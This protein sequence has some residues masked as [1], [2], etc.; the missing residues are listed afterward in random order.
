MEGAKGEEVVGVKKGVVGGGGVRLEARI[1][2][3]K[4]WWQFRPLMATNGREKVG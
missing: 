4:W 2:E 3:G 1:E